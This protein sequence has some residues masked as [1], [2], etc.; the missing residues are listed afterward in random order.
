M[1]RRR[2]PIGGRGGGL[3]SPLF[4]AGWP[5]GLWGAACG[6]AAVCVGRE[7]HG[8]LLWLG[9]ESIPG[10]SVTKDELCLGAH[11]FGSA[12]GRS[13]VR[14]HQMVPEARDAHLAAAMLFVV[15]QSATSGHT[16]SS[17]R[18]PAFGRS[19]LEGWRFRSPRSSR[20]TCFRRALVRQERARRAARVAAEAEI[21]RGAMAGVC[22]GAHHT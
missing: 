16:D 9:L 15:L 13:G 8:L 1:R 20:V 17:C 10:R 4:V 3:S 19:N 12:D 18:M 11:V 5:W 2:R 22:H 14:D 21:G 7:V 6:R